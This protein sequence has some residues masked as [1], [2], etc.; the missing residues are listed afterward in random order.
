M[1]EELRYSLDVAVRV[2]PWD[3]EWSD[4][5]QTTLLAAG[6]KGCVGTACRFSSGPDSRDGSE[7]VAVRCADICT[8]S[9]AVHSRVVLPTAKSCVGFMDGSNAVYDKVAASS[10]DPDATPTSLPS[11]RLLGGVDECLSDMTRM[12]CSNLIS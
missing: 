9:A 3:I 7:C 6:I 5:C 4:A 11:A 12:K 8:D 2:E 10:E 1:S